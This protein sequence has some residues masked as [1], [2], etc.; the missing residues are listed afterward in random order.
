MN[1]IISKLIKVVKY[2]SF[3]IIG[4]ILS[5][6]I[7]DH[8]FLKG[9]YFQSK[10]MGI[11]AIGWEW[12]VYDAIGRIIF[13]A[14][15][16]VKW[17]VSPK[18]TVTHPKNIIFD[19]NDLHIFHTYGTYF[20]AI[21]AKIII[22][23]GCWIAPNVGLITANHDINNLSKHTKGKDIKIGKNCWIGMNSVILPGVEIGDNTIIGAGSVVTKSFVEGNCI[24]AG[25]PAKLVKHLVIEQD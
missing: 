21:D 1:M 23:K 6:F 25:N 12:V 22:G 10:Y 18:I 14:N 16:N 13:N 3:Y 24:V 5:I 9:T 19:I 15:K 20:Q 11:G 4:N 7:Y 2:F 8:K 17:P